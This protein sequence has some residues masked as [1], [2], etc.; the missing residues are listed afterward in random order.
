[1]MDGCFYKTRL[2]LF[3]KSIHT[4]YTK[5]AKVGHQLVTKK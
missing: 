3:F 5:K 1:M 4:F 2:L